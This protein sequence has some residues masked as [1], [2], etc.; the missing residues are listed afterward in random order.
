VKVSKEIDDLL[1]VNEKIRSPS[2]NDKLFI[3]A[4]DWR[5]NAC[6]SLYG[7]STESYIKGYKEAADLLVESVAT[8]EG[9]ADFLIYP[10][11]FLYRH[12]LELRLKSLLH[13]GNRLLNR[14][15][16]QKS[17][18]SFS[19]LWSEVRKILVELWSNEEGD[20]LKAMD[21]LIEQFQTVDPNSTSFRY[22]KDLKGE[23]SLKIGSRVLNLRNLA[24]VVKAM[25]TILDGSATA[26]SVYQENKDE[27]QS[28]CW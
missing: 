2:L 23:N 8:G 3:G 15:Y 20:Q 16:K 7:D 18:H 26:I 21:S 12:Y 6:L 24:E 13:D 5:M 9:T 27:M 28:D 14:Y 11:V 17:V 19:K 10:I 1:N 4:E 22:A 25:S